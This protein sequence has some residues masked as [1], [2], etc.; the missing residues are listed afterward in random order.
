MSSGSESP[1]PQG[2]SPIQPWNPVPLV[3]GNGVEDQ[4]PPIVYITPPS[5]PPPKASPVATPET[6]EGS[7]TSIS[8]RRNFR[9]ANPDLDPDPE[10][11]P[12]VYTPPPLPDL[13]TDSSGP[14]PPLDV[15]G[16]AYLRPNGVPPTSKPLETS[17][18]AWR[19]AQSRSSTSGWSGSDETYSYWQKPPTSPISSIPTSQ[20]S[21][22]RRSGAHSHHSSGRPHP[23]EVYDNLE[24]FF[25]NFDFDQTVT[26]CEDAECSGGRVNRVI[27]KVV[28]EQSS[29]VSSGPSSSRRATKL[30][31][32]KVEELGRNGIQ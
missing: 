20:N 12:F 19:S 13:E 7:S 4:G 25:P 10:Q 6:R 14:A 22:G 26:A 1:I 29:R 18:S 11:S 16:D 23:T 32:C 9:I 24:G 2:L 17:P 30:W 31:D 15:P 8:K 3:S 27:R 28:E 21:T 5:S